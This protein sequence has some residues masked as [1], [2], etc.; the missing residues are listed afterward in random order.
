MSADEGPA[1]DG[2]GDWDEVELDEAF[3]RSAP[4]VEPSGRARM[5]AARWRRE[6]PEPEPWR[7]DRPPAGWFW[8]KARRGWWRRR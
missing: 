2:G 7:S 8:S 3:V 1:G 5:L 4:A 6:P